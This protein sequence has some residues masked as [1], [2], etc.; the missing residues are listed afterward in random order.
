[1]SNILLGM[2]KHLVKSDGIHHSH[3]V[4]WILSISMSIQYICNIFLVYIKCMSSIHPY[5]ICR[6]NHLR[7]VYSIQP[8][9]ML[10]GSPLGGNRPNIDQASTE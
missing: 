3:V 6:T 8:S 2:V 1:M 5:S 4:R 9:P 7:I 10:N